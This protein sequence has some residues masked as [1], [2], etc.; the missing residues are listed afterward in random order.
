MRFLSVADLHY[1]LPQFDWVV[2]AARDFDIVIMAGDHLDLSSLVDRRAQRV[3]VRKYFS[4]LSER[5][6]LLVC[7]GNHDLDAESD[8]GEKVARWLNAP[9]GEGIA[10][11]GDSFVLEDTLFTLCPWWDGAVTRAGIA[12]QLEAASA[13]RAKHWVWIHHAPP[14]KTPVSWGGARFFG[15]SQ[16]SEWIATYQP[17][18]VL[19]GH[20]HPAPFLK[21][22]SWVD[23]IGQT[24]VFNA[25][26][27]FGAPP[28]FLIVDTDRAQALWFSAAGCQCVDLG[29]PL[30]RPVT[31]LHE[32]PAWLKAG[33]RSGPPALE[34]ARAPDGA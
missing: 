21:D 17:D 3:V 28:S 34:A 15:D 26:H 8:A 29:E 11:D 4:R 27:Q 5:V 30:K 24:W 19:S 12:A 18:M 14:D 31:K 13:A 25:G 20:V 1:S 23:R 33:S 9:L 22:G 6:R 2:D 7:S 16:L 32:M 10:T